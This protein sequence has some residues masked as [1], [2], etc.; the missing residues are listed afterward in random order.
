MSLI[1]QAAEVNYARPGFWNHVTP[2]GGSIRKAFDRYSAF[3]LG[4]RAS[5]Q[6]GEAPPT[7]S[8]W[9]Y[10]MAYDPWREARFRNVILTAPRNRFI[11]Q[12][13]ASPRCCWARR[14]SPSRVAGALGRRTRRAGASAR[15]SVSFIT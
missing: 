2:N 5:P 14:C 12:S 7:N 3:I 13:T 6:A 11:I 4:E 9:L 15:Y 8:A 10:E 1:A